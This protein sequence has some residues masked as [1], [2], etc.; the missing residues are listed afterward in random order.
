MQITRIALIER[1]SLDNSDAG[2]ES[3]VKLYQLRGNEKLT[4]YAASLNKKKEKTFNFHAKCLIHGQKIVFFF[5]I[6]SNINVQ[7]NKQKVH[8]FLL[9]RDH[10][11]CF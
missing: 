1:R 2:F 7:T 8:C 11:S 3:P 9:I 5:L 6:S 10:F 4:K